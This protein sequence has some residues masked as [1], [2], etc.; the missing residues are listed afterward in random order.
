MELSGKGQT[1]VRPLTKGSVGLGFPPRNVSPSSALGAQR[2]SS[3]RAQAHCSAVS[4]GRPRPCP[5]LCI[6]PWLLKCWIPSSVCWLLG[7]LLPPGWVWVPVTDGH[8]LGN[9]GTSWPA[10]PYIS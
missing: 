5:R 2:S 6:L 7:W 3:R 4:V 9:L 1:K 10:C 8:L